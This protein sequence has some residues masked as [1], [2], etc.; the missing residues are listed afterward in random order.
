MRAAFGQAFVFGLAVLAG[1]LVT[2]GMWMWSLWTQF[3]NPIFPHANIWFKSP[4]G[5]V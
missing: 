3:R 4:V 2:A 5:R 1:T